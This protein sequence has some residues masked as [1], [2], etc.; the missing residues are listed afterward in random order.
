MKM[1]DDCDEDGVYD[2]EAVLIASVSP[3]ADA[4]RSSSIILL[5]F[6]STTQITALCL[7]PGLFW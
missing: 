6:M 4:E 7:L 2:G 1:Q 3:A 5:T